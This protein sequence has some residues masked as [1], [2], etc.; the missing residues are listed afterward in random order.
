MDVD[1][2]RTFAQGVMLDTIGVPITV[3]RPVPFDDP[4]VASGIWVALPLDETRPMGMDFQRRES[5]KVMAIVRTATLPTLP[6][7]STI[8]APELLNGPV[9]NWRVDGFERPVEVDEWRVR[10]VLITDP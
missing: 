2:L 5:R 1:A 4:V 7:A 10:L 8:L 6:N 3:T 9:R